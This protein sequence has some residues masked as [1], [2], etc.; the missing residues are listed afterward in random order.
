MTSTGIHAVI[1]AFFAV[2]VTSFAGMDATDPYANREAAK[3]SKDDA[4]IHARLEFARADRDGDDALSVDEY[5][6]LTLITAE[7]AHLNGFIAVE[8]GDAAG[9]VM[10]IS[11]PAA[12]AAALSRG[13]QA[14]IDAVA[15]NRFYGAAGD[16][17][18]LDEHEFVALQKSVFDSADSNRNGAL[19]KNELQI[20]ASR[21]ANLRAGV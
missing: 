12:S 9:E 2:T 7:L 8:R 21:R 1:A 19:H 18:A 3:L 16:D 20:F 10:T 14:R 5:A 11:L 15:R 13:E 17:A 6:A 4:A